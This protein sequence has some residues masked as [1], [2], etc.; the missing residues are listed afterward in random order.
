MLDNSLTIVDPDGAVTVTRLAL[1]FELHL[2]VGDLITDEAGGHWRVEEIDVEL[3]NLVVAVVA[4]QQGQTIE[5]L[6]A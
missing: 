1:E 6:A 2:H 5:L 4:P 3:R